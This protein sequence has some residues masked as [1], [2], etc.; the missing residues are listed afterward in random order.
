MG[1]SE[2]AYP[3]PA[4]GIDLIR[5][6]EVL[7]AEKPGHVA[8]SLQMLLCFTIGLFAAFSRN[9]F[10]TD[11]PVI[12]TLFVVSLGM[13][14][15][16]LGFV[17]LTKQLRVFALGYC[18]MAIVALFLQFW[19]IVYLLFVAKHLD[20]GFAFWALILSSVL[21]IAACVL[22]HNSGLEWYLG[23]RQLT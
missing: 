8:C 17:A 23:G 11:L 18:V 7:M 16:G 22:A 12:T 4:V 10:D 19:N 15:S 14:T 9:S 3:G 5:D 6:S 21:E 20:A 1:Q 2:A 13:T